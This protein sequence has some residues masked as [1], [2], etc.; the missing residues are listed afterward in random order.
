MAYKPYKRKK[1]NSIA[2]LDREIIRL[3][4][5]RRKLGSM[6]EN[7]VTDLQSNFFR[8]TLNSILGHSPRQPNWLGTTINNFLN[9]DD[10][11]SGIKQL[12]E[13]IN[14]KIKTLFERFTKRSTH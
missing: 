7:N 14:A 12:F 1:V 2:E 9:S 8:M 4:W 5:R 11:K 13:T 10:I 3:K 6:L